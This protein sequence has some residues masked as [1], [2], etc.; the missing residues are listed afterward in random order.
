M[1]FFT[2]MFHKE[3]KKSNT[4]VFESYVTLMLQSANIKITD[5]N[6]LKATVYLLYAQLACLHIASKGTSAVFVDALVDD[7]RK[8]ILTLTM[9]VKDLAQNKTELKRIISGFPK[10]AGVD[11]DTTVNGLAAFEAIYFQYFEEVIKDI[12]SHTDGPMGCHGYAAVKF[13]EALKGKRGADSNML[14]SSMLMT[15]MTGEVIKAFR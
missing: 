14:E 6:R 5:A 15:Q 12:A 8:S 13:L 2:K 3:V 1:N 10:Q 4:D 7:V 11:G 9:K